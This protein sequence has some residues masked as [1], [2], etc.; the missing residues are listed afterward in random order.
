M[1]QQQLLLT[2]AAL[3]SQGSGDAG[4][5][6]KELSAIAE[7]IRLNIE[8]L[9]A[10][11]KDVDK[12]LGSLGTNGD[13]R[14][15]EA[16]FPPSSAAGRPAEGD[17]EQTAKTDAVPVAQEQEQE[18]E[19]EPLPR[20]LQPLL[21]TVTMQQRLAFLLVG[22]SRTFNEEA[23]RR[24]Y[25]SHLLEPLTALLHVDL[26]VSFNTLNDTRFFTPSASVEEVVQWVEPFQPHVVDIELQVDADSWS[27]RQRAYAAMAR[28]EQQLGLRYDFVLMARPD[29]QFNLKEWIDIRTWKVWTASLTYAAPCKCWR[30][31]PNGELWAD[32]FAVFDRKIADAYF[33]V[34]RY[35][36]AD[37]CYFYQDRRDKYE[38]AIYN[39]I[40]GAFPNVTFERRAGV[41]GVEFILFPLRPH[42]VSTYKYLQ[43]TNWGDA[44]IAE[45]PRFWTSAEGVQRALPENLR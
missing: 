9:S 34:S 45:N 28:R 40:V 16:T 39:R 33:N 4:A 10:L 21:K 41:N 22:Q 14:Q 19:Q 15:A 20:S 3:F 44:T 1:M 29:L 38:C 23:V 25:K 31:P 36:F 17:R 2:F 42:L 12:K 7:D 6:T 5:T 13:Q 24:P 26:F 8:Q 18:Q 30:K 11:A 37:R 35:P 32:T 27:N 43:E